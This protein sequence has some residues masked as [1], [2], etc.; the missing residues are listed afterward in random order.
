MC[1]LPGQKCIQIQVDID[2]I[3][4]FHHS[5]FELTYIEVID[6]RVDCHLT[7]SE[8]VLPVLQLGRYT[9]SI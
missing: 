5:R 6:G 9:K 7:I 1:Q 3:G 2:L 8:Q 4:H